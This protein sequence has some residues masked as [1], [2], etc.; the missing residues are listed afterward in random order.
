MSRKKSSKS[1]GRPIS[2]IDAL[3]LY[4]APEDVRRRALRQSRRRRDRERERDSAPSRDQNRRN[5]RERRYSE[6][7]PPARPWYEDQE[8]NDDDCSCCSDESSCSTCDGR[9]QQSDGQPYMPFPHGVAQYQQPPSGVE[10][11][12]QPP[13]V[14]A[15]EHMPSAWS[16]SSSE[17]ASQGPDTNEPS[18]FNRMMN[19]MNHR[20]TTLPVISQPVPAQHNGPVPMSRPRNMSYDPAND[21]LYAHI[22]RRQGQRYLGEVVVHRHR[23]E[24]RNAF[25]GN[26]QFFEDPL[27]QSQFL[28]NPRPAP[29]PPRTRPLSMPVPPSPHPFD[30]RR[31]V[32]ANTHGRI[33]R[34]RGDVEPVPEEA[35]GPPPSEV[36]SHASTVWPRFSGVNGSVVDPTDSISEVNARSQR[37]SRR[38]STYSSH[39]SRRPVPRRSSGASRSHYY[40]PPPQQ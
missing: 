7:P 17:L 12:Q 5:G 40:Y 30:N 21:P 18:F 36:N 33:S 4:T 8:D 16:Y 11:Y 32:S 13:S 34:W 20:N 9:E 14:D 29:R 1:R 2:F 22:P 31:Y 6:V 38:S 24:E 37:D 3:A 15:E 23:Q 27:E 19:R 39:V 28:T 26:E 10:Q 25:H 35:Y